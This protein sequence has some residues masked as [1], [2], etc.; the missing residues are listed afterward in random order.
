MW[1]GVVRCGDVCWVRW[2]WWIWCLENVV[3]FV[4]MLFIALEAGYFCDGSR[5]AVGL[6]GVLGVERGMSVEGSASGECGWI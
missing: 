6:V 1:Q 5:G 3:W 4:K 2:V